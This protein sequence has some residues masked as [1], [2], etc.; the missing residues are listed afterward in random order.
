MEKSNKDH[1][2]YVR[3]GV[4]YY[5]VWDDDM[6][7]FAVRSTPLLEMLSV[8]V[9]SDL[10][11]DCDLCEI[12]GTI[13]VTNGLGHALD[14]YNRGHENP[15]FI[16]PDETSYSRYLSL[17]G[18]K[19]GRVIIPYEYV[20]VD[21]DLRDRA[22]D[23]IV[24]AKGKLRFSYKETFYTEQGA[25]RVEG[26]AGFVTLHYATFPFAVAA[27][28]DV[29]FF[30]KDDDFDTINYDPDDYGNDYADYDSGGYGNDD[31][32]ADV[33]GIVAAYTNFPGSS[34]FGD[35][36]T[37]SSILLNMPHNQC[38]RVTSRTFIELS[39]SVV[40]VPAYSNSPL[41]IH[42][43]FKH[44]DG[45]RLADGILKFKVDN[46][47]LIKKD[48]VGEN[49]RIRVRVKWGDAYEQRYGGNALKQSLNKVSSPEREESKIEQLVKRQ[50]FG[51]ALQPSLAITD[52]SLSSPVLKE[53]QEYRPREEPMQLL[54][55][56]SVGI[57]SNFLR[58]PFKLYGEIEVNDCHLFNRDESS[59]QI[60][61][62]KI[63]VKFHRRSG[64]LT[65]DDF[66]IYVDLKDVE[67][68][69]FVEGQISWPIRLLEP[70]YDKR[71]CD[72]VRGDR[73]YVA[74]HY[75]V[76]YDGL[77]AKV[78]VLLRWINCGSNYDYLPTKV[79]GSLAARYSNHE[80]SISYDEKY[81][82]SV[83]FESGSDDPVNL[84]IDGSLPLSKSLV[85][86]PRK[87]S[88]IIKADLT[89]ADS[90]LPQPAGPSGAA[91]IDVLQG[92][93]EFN[94]D[95]GQSCK[96]IWGQNYSINISVKWPK[97]W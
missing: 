94:A 97:I 90:S 18:L 87:S 37:I 33:Y 84:N 83:L 21:M 69:V 12:Y 93:V 42:V 61:F 3:K 39:R 88:L 23:D 60:C 56:F 5:Q 66:G 74:V 96:D 28:V 16:K 31:A 24:I 27:T 53:K 55:V 8:S 2:D 46:C 95:D 29:L 25:K 71:I 45:S 4:S 14:L 57:G 30:S 7:N 43:D 34:S 64:F 1:M 78:K 40:A 54:E 22:R 9:H 11:V 50:R 73:G 70:W 67:G 68:N 79:Y 26:D 6:P 51:V 48:L 20:I 44:N 75:M 32:V 35:D 92:S 47:G 41:Q 80:Y 38:V 91:G 58:P 52:W 81:Y 15:E 86:V 63:E 19:D 89:V 13:K 65:L 85:C 72:L 62:D 10:P 17:T 77:Q 82:Q 36:T 49:G 59:P 76:I